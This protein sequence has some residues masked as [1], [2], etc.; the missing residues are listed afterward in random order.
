MVDLGGTTQSGFDVDADVRL[1]GVMSDP[2][3]RM[4]V[5]SIA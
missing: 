3:A 1:A 2:A 5:A 4:P